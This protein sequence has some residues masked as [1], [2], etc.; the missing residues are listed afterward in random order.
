MLKK[1]SS[2]PFRGTPEQKA[3]LQAV[4]D[5]SKSDKSLLMHVMQ[6][7]QKLGLISV[8]SAS[9]RTVITLTA[10]LSTIFPDDPTKGDFAL[11]GYG[12]TEK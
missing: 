3:Q 11:F 8:K 1:I 5:E 6:E 9:W 2:I 10:A 12:I 4:I 7:A